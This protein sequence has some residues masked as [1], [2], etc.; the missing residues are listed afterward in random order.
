[1][2]SPLTPPTDSPLAIVCALIVVAWTLFFHWYYYSSG[3][4]Y[5]DPPEYQECDPTNKAGHPIG[6]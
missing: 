4:A 6:D 1:M 3:N 2:P 5:S